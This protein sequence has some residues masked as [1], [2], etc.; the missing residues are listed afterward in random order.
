M[1][2]KQHRPA[3]E[4]YSQLHH[5]VCFDSHSWAVLMLIGARELG[6]RR[7]PLLDLQQILGGQIE[8]VLEILAN[9]RAVGLRNSFLR[10]IADAVQN[11]LVEDLKIIQ[12]R[13]ALD[14]AK[15]FFAT[16]NRSPTEINPQHVVQSLHF[17]GASPLIL[18]LN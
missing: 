11:I 18:G 6:V 13:A 15:E 7:F 9:R 4:V 1:S 16:R 5:A 8:Q 2:M 10:R 14:S 3:W 12:W 17:R